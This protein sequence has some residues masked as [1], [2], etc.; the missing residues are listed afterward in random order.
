LTWLAQLASLEIHVPQWRFGRNGQPR[1]PDRLVLDLDPG[2]GVT[3]TDCAEIALLVR[4]I[5]RD[6]GHDP[7][8]VTS[9]SKGIHLY[10]P[11]DG[12]L[13]SDQ[14]TEVARE[15]ALALEA[16][17]RDRVI[18]SMKRSDRD[19]K[20]FIDW[21]QNNGAK[22]T[23]SPYS[24][25]GRDHPMVAAPRTWEEIAGPE[26]TQLDYT[27]V[28]SRLSDMGDLLAGMAGEDTRPD[29]LST[30]R[31][32]RDA[33]K[34]PEPV[35]AEPAREDE[36]GFS[37]VIQEHHARALHYDFRLERH[38][39]LVSWAVPKAPPTDPKVNHLAV[40]TEDHPLEYGSFEGS[41]PRGEYGGGQ[42]SI[43]DAGTYKLHKWREGKEVI[44]T[45]FGKP[46]GG[47][48]GV[49]KFALI[50][51]GGGGSR[52]E[53]NW[54]MHLMQTDPEDEVSLRAE[55]V[56]EQS[57]TSE[58][59]FPEVIEP[60]LATLTTVERFGPEEGWAFEMKWDGV[61]T[62]AYLAGGKVKLLSRKG[63]NDTAAYFDV[64]PDLAAIEV[65][66]AVL[67]GEVVV[68]DPVG[69]PNFGL[70]QHRINLTR[71]A[72]IER[73][74]KTWPAQLM[75]FDILHLNGRSLIKLPYAGR[76]EILEGLVQP[77]K[78]SR[79]QVP[80]VFDGNLHAAMDTSKDLK[81]EGVVAKQ[82]DSVYQPGRR[83]RTWLKLKPH[84]AQEV[85]IGGWR[86][87]QG[88]RDG[89]IGSLLLGIPTAD[90]LRYIGR[91]GSGFN[92]RQLDEIQTMLDRLARKTSPLIDVPRED[93]RDAHWVTPS[94]VG[95]VTYGELTEPG[96]LRHP[97]WR[98]LRPDK[99][100]DEVK[101]EGVDPDQVP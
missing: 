32:M 101:W 71:P 89:G 22:T 57:A 75:L 82:V 59:E 10:A 55:P 2:P 87:G 35:P 72:D 38:G 24:L 39:V 78:G 52:P 15:L 16:D 65:E 13:S 95:E 69:R 17:H 54:L 80:P 44:V 45:L 61:R 63:R 34:T 94:L 96:R 6:I 31:S 37:F 62:V 41:I 23:V 14:A 90:G 11:L 91:V 48:G 98:G 70:L 42:V 66:T 12:S 40:Q 19:G 5:L 25:R 8:P 84:P 73:A 79:L 26:L 46:D 29:R 77:E 81:L 36:E 28:A 7:V 20:V 86:P 21:S 3:L 9:G 67:D 85:I 99:S 47:L 68:T 88:R 49:R 74:A 18:S 93:A 51:T 60:M 76:R 33:A 100:P 1:N 92:D 50:H 4:D 56:A 30:Y 97:V 53:R 43:W 83:A 64:V 58:P 27:Q